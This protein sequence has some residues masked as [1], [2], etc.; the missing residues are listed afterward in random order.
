MIGVKYIQAIKTKVM[1]CAISLK[2]TPN[3]ATSQAAEA[4]ILQLAPA[5]DIV[6]DDGSHQSDD[7]LRAFLIYFE[8]V[9]PG[10]LYIVEDTHTLF[11]EAYGGGIL[12]RN[13]ADLGA[14]VESRFPE[15]RPPNT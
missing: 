13:S 7:V 11:W 4:Q 2:K 6:I 12:K 8:H 3:D 10:G 5:F 15:P 1:P 14:D 9:V